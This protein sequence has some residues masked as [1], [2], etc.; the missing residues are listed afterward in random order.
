MTIV[1]WVVTVFVA[2]VSLAAAAAVVFALGRTVVELTAVTA[3]IASG[4][5]GGARAPNVSVSHS[6][7][8]R[9][10]DTGCPG[11]FLWM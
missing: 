9:G 5:G 1:I 10:G 7:S 4:S 11:V 3:V 8:G 6:V 2:A